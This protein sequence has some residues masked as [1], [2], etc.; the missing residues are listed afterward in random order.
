M[1]L[2]TAMKGR[3]LLS[4]NDVSDAELLY[5]LDLAAELKEKKRSGATGDLLTGRNIAMIF[6]KMSTRTRFAA[7]V[8]VA[9]EAGTAECIS[10]SEIHIGKKESVEDTARVLGRMF[11]GILFRGY[12]QETAGQLAEHAGIPVW[13]G[14]TDELHP[15]QILAD[16]LTIRENFGK[17]KGLK[18]VYVG[19]GRNNVAN[20]LM[21]GCAKTGMRFVDCTPDELTPQSELVGKANDIAERNGGSVSVV[22]DPAEAVAQA[23]VVYTDA[24]VSMG[25]EEKTAERIKTLR[26]YQ[27]NMDLMEKTEKIA[28]DEVIFL[29]CLPA[30]HDGSTDLTKETGAL[31]V[32]DEVFGSP[33]SKVFDQAENKMHT[34]KA[35]IV[36][37]VH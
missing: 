8:A 12:S 27:V 2:D 18:V 28:S 25:E 10:S 7:A 1:K 35:L 23:N 21:V 11:D 32:T 19:D 13:N 22:Q 16:L 33:F 24:W 20:S 26:P 31:E 15:T 17:L 4:L 30:L 37:T 36:A 9:D 5:L 14:L 3:S 34:L 29:H 6:E